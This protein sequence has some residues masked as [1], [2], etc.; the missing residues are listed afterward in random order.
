MP[1]ERH[2]EFRGGPWVRWPGEE[3][4]KTR[5]A[6]QRGR[7]ASLWLRGRGSQESARRGASGCPVPPGRWLR[8]VSGGGAHAC[9]YTQEGAFLSSEYEYSCN[10]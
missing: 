3:S 10:K 1:N 9:S 2:E 6:G 8:H 4:S 5:G 7:G